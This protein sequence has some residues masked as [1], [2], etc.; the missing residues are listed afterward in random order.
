MSDGTLPVASSNVIITLQE[1]ITSNEYNQFKEQTDL[2]ALQQI[3]NPNNDVLR[4]K[5]FSWAA[6][7]FPVAFTLME[8]EINPPDICADGQR[9]TK[10]EYIAYLLKRP[11]GHFLRD[12]ETKIPGIGL[13]YSTPDMKVCI[14]CEKL[15]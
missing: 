4:S 12:L 2:A 13:S 6:S 9:R 11:L 7:G 1:L 14:H 8:T 10:F 5:L 3:L 15:N